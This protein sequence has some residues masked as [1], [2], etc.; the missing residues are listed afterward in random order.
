[1]ITQPGKCGHPLDAHIETL[2]RSSGD[3]SIPSESFR[4]MGLKDRREAHRARVAQCA[5]FATH[6]SL[7]SKAARDI[8]F[9]FSNTHAIASKLWRC[10]T[11]A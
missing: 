1:V 8:K 6:N 5:I 2:F 10:S 4:A 9:P 11:P 3:F 7:K